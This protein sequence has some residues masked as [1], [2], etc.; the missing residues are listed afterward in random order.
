[1]GSGA[2]RFSSAYSDVIVDLPLPSFALTTVNGRTVLVAGGVVAAG[3]SLYVSGQA[4]QNST[5]DANLI[6]YGGLTVA[7]AV[8]L[9]SGHY[10]GNEVITAD[11]RL[12]SC[13]LTVLAGG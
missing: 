1:S 8:T 10:Y 9:S 3:Q 12:E 7:G 4:L 6:V 2:V 11:L 5:L 13:D